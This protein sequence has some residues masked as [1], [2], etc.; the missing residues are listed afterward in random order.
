MCR[1]R[2]CS[3]GDS[4][5]CC[6]MCI[7]MLLPLFNISC[8]WRVDNEVVMR[9]IE[10]IGIYWQWGYAMQLYCLVEST[11]M[12]MSQH[13]HLDHHQQQK[14]KKHHLQMQL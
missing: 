8:M 4:F 1:Y 5:H 11:S 10:A 3:A 13:H 6:K 7:D 12:S 2:Q 9:C 14:Q